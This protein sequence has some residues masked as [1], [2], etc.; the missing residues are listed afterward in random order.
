MCGHLAHLQVIQTY[1]LFLSTLMCI[2]Y[3]NEERVRCGSD[4][5]HNTLAD[6]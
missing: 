3:T 4:R 1:Y 2:T 5:N 6:R